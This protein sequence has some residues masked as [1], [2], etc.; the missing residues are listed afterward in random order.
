MYKW[1]CQICGEMNEYQDLR[2]LR[3]CECHYCQTR[4]ISSIDEN[5]RILF[6]EN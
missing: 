3:S 2:D 5:G 4:R 6:K 1:I